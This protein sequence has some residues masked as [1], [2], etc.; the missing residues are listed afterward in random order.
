MRTKKSIINFLIQN[1]RILIGIIFAL[2]VT[3]LI[4]KHLG[5]ERFGA[6]KTLID[7]MGYFTL[8]ELG[9]YGSL[10]IVLNKAISNNNLNDQKNYL[11]L[12][13][14]YYFIVIIISFISAAIA[15]PFI[16]N[17]IRVQSIYYS[18]I[19]WA[20]AIFTSLF[21]LLLIRP[22]QAYLEASQKNYYTSIA[23]IAM[24][25]I[26]NLSAIAFVK[27][28]FGIKGQITAYA[29]GVLVSNIILFYFYRK[30]TAS[31]RKKWKNISVSIKE[32]K[33]D[34]FQIQK[35]IL[36]MQLAG[37]FGLYSDTIILSF[38]MSPVKVSIFY[39]TQRAVSIL[40]DF[41]S[42]V[43]N[44]TWA[45]LGE[46][47]HQKEYER[48]NN[49][50]IFITKIGSISAV[51]VLVPV[52]FLNKSFITVWIGSDLYAG[53]FFTLII[54]Y[55]AFLLPIFSFWGWCFTATGHIID[56]NKYVIT[57]TFINIILSIIFTYYF[58]IIGPILGTLLTHILYTIWWQNYHLKKFFHIPRKQL[59]KSWLPSFLYLTIMA[60]LYF[61]LRSYFL[62]E[63]WPDFIL[64]CLLIGSVNFLIVFTLLVNSKDRLYFKDRIN[65]LLDKGSN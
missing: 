23:L 12:G 28:G 16:T 37:K 13:R 64:M 2:I 25:I 4:V 62:F 32:K 44:S 34:F 42:G 50:I 60:L 18:D 33:D 39:I 52:I 1:S 6:Y 49:L 14:R 11:L 51:I 59:I 41:L 58:H 57:T 46:L 36:L 9:I 35:P 17:L 56:L 48:F 10:Q 38:F 5:Q 21:F 63:S 24:T 19:K 43:G 30:S 3:P 45:S 54:I 65:R 15:F 47:F 55:N 31:I 7:F 22:Y 8:L 53:D 26:F 27:I 61:N 29:L 20:Y 40:S